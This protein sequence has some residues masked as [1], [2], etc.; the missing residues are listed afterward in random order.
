MGLLWV[1]GLVVSQESV[2]DLIQRC[3][4]YKSIDIGVEIIY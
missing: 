3:L 2:S 1:T 4:M